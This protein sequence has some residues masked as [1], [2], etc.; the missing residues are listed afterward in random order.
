MKPEEKRRFRAVRRTLRDGREVRLRFL[1]RDDGDRLAAFY[2]RVPRRDFRFYCPYA[3]TAEQARENAARADDPRRIV[4]VLE[5]TADGSIG[6]YAWCKWA[7]DDATASTFGICVRPDFQGV[8]AGRALMTR[9][10]AIAARGGPP[11]M[12]LTVQRANAGAVRLYRSLGF[13]ITREQER[14]PRFGFSPEPEYRMRRR[15]R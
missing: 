5:D 1:R 10:L 9:L 2:A 11:D 15:M 13:E 3:L 6:G 8:G 14:E 4:L 12:E 7:A